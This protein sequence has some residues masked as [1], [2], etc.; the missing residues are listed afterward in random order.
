[1]KL[2]WLLAILAFFTLI[3]C[4]KDPP[5]DNAQTGS[6]PSKIDLRT[7]AAQYVY[8]TT[9]ELYFEILDDGGEDL[10]AVG[11]CWSTKEQPTIAD[12]SYSPGNKTGTYHTNAKNLKVDT[13][14]YARAYATNRFGTVYGNRVSFITVPLLPGIPYPTASSIT[15]TT[16]LLQG[17][18]TDDGGSK[19]TE[20]GFIWD[21]INDLRLTSRNRIAV[22]SDTGS[23]STS[24]SGLKPG[25]YYYFAAYATNKAGTSMNR[26]GFVAANPAPPTVVTS[27]GIAGSNVVAGGTITAAE[28]ITITSRGIITIPD[29][30]P[31]L[32]SQTLFM[33]SGTGTFQGILWHAASGSRS[34]VQAFANYNFNYTGSGSV[35]G[36]IVELVVP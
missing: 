16:A 23:F 31:E 4:K 11:I 13:R 18:I 5:V 3:S 20:R 34:R 21:T 6:N 9:T 29:F 10:L 24:I 32:T 8:N 7:L 22:G 12:S 14:Y 28:G 35:K 27:I 36:N 30:R 26:S 15:Q 1:M 25:F 19:V 33:G 2:K 17:R